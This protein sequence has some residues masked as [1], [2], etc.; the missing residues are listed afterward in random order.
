MGGGEGGGNTWVIL[1]TGGI[2]TYTA[3]GTVD[4]LTPEFTQNRHSQNFLGAHAWNGH[5]LLPLGGGGLMEL[6]QGQLRDISLSQSLP[7]LTDLHGPVVAITS[8][9]TEVYILVLDSANT[10]YYLLLGRY[11]VFDGVADWRWHQLGEVSYTTGTKQEHATLFY[12]ASRDDRRRVWIG[13]YSSGSNLY[14]YFICTGDVADDAGDGFTNDTDGQAVTVDWDGNF[15]HVE[16][17]FSKVDF[18]V[19]NLGAGGR[20]FTVAYSIDG[21]A[22]ATDLTDSAGNADGVVDTTGETQTLTFPRG[23]SGKK[24]TLRFIP[25][26]TTVGTTSPE[27]LSFRVT[28]QLRPDAIKMLPLSA[29]LED[30]QLLLNGTIGGTPKADLSQLK[31]WD[32]QAAEVRVSGPDGN[33]YDCVF[34]PG[35]LRVTELAHEP[36]RRPSYRAD[37]VVAEVAR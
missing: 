30:Q 8:S 34:L 26:L 19:D 7:E 11:A 9:A 32:N 20:L 16:K 10:K 23:K 2:Y 25:A 22:Y 31:T 14:P 33:N 28:A 17:S 24:I 1:K 36:G 15:P 35:S 3:D 21:A 5:I 29:V 18:E 13:V 37:F 27:L 12:D 6:Y 4:H